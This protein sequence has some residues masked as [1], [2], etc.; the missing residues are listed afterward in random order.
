MKNCDM[1]WVRPVLGISHLFELLYGVLNLI[2]GT[3]IQNSHEYLELEFGSS[4]L[5]N[6]DNC[7]SVF[8]VNYEV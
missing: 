3:K 1:N 5:W 6:C 4:N 7:L 8:S 2:S